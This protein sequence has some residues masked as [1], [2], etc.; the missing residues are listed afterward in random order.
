MPVIISRAPTQLL[1]YLA[2]QK[3]KTLEKRCNAAGNFAMGL[4]HS[5]GLTY[6][7]Y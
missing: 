4:G 7:V 1:D 2:E 6:S 5:D 3:R